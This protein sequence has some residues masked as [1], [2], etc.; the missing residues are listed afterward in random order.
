MGPV[1]CVPSNFEEPGDQVCL[2]PFKFG[3]LT[4][5]C[6]AQ[7]V[8]L[9]VIQYSLD[10]GLN[11]GPQGKLLDLRGVQEWIRCR[12]ASVAQWANAVGAAGQ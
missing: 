9:E 12:P 7:H 6:R 2:V 4:F 5:F 8:T 1:R 11:P 10:V 3:D